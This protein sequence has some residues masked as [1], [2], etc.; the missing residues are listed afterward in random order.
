MLGGIEERRG[1]ISRCVP[2]EEGPRR[3]LR[4]KQLTPQVDKCLRISSR[5]ERSERD[6]WRPQPEGK[7]AESKARQV[8]ASISWS[9]K[10][11]GEEEERTMKT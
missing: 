3:R 8:S 7:E 2:G 1:E 10:A 11:G 6:P 9:E 5:P 4:A